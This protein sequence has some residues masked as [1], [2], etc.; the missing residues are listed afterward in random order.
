[1]NPAAA[2]LVA[3]AEDYPW[4]SAVAHLTRQDDMLVKA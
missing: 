4:S 3:R 2:G 1:M